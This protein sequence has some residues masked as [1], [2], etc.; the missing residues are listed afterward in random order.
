MADTSLNDLQEMQKLTAS[1]TKDYDNLLKGHGKVNKA[2]KSEVE[3]QKSIVS[4]IKD[5]VT[6]E[7]AIEKLKKRHI[8]LGTKHW[9]Y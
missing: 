5:A 1:M 8:S 3:L 2:L 7:E 9:F 4:G 6:A